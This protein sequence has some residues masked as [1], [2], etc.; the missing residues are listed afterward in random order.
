LGEFAIGSADNPV[1]LLPGVEFSRTFT[2]FAP[3]S[4][5][6]YYLIA[7][8][9]SGEAVSEGSGSGETNNITV[10]P[11][12]VSPAYRASVYT[13]ASTTLPRASVLLRGQALSN[14]NSSPVPYEFVKIG[15]ENKGTVRELDAFTDANGFFTRQFT[16]LDGEGGL[17]NIKAY[18]PGYPQEDPAPEDSFTILGMRFEQGDQRLTQLNPRITEGTTFAGSV[19]LQNLSATALT[20]LT[21]QAVGEPSDW[22]VQLSFPK[23]TLVGDEE[24]QIN[25]SI[26]VPD[27]KWSY[28][29]FG[30]AVSSAE[31]VQASLPVRVDV[32]QL[33]PKLVANQ[34]ILQASMLRGGQTLVEFQVRNEGAI[35]TGP[36]ELRLPNAPFLRA[37]SPLSLPSLNVGETTKVSLLLQPGADQELTVYNGSIVVAGA[38]ATLTLPFNFRAVSEA[39]GNLSLSVEDELTYFAEGSPLLGNATITLLDPFSGAVIF[40]ESDAD[41]VLLKQ[42]LAEGYYKLRVTADNHDSYEHTFYLGAGETESIQAFLSRQTVKYIWTV[43]PTEIEDK[44]TISIESVFETDVP[45]PVVTIDP[46][47]IDLQD[48]QVVGQ[49]MQMNMTLTNH[50]LIAANDIKLDFTSHPFYKL[51]PLLN[52]VDSLAAKSSLTIPVRITRINDFA[53]P[54]PGGGG[55]V[56]GGGGGGGGGGVGGGGGEPGGGSDPGNGSNPSTGIGGGNIDRNSP[57]SCALSGIVQWSYPCGETDITK[58]TEIVFW[59]VEGNCAPG[60]GSIDRS[61]GGIPS[62]DFGGGGGGGGGVISYMPIIVNTSNCNPCINEVSDRAKNIWLNLVSCVPIIGCPVGTYSCYD[63]VSDKDITWKDG[64]GCFSAVLGCAGFSL[65][66][67]SISIFLSY[68]EFKEFFDSCHGNGSFPSP[69]IPS[70][71]ESLATGNAQIFAYANL[72][73]AFDQIDKYVNRAQA[74]INSFTVI[75]GDNIWLKDQETN[76]ELKIWMEAFIAKTQGFTTTETT[77]STAERNELLGF[78]LPGKVSINDANQ[79]IDRWNRTVDYWSQGILNAIDVPSGQST[80]FISLDAVRKAFSQAKKAVIQNQAEGFDNASDGVIYAVDQLNRALE[81][82]SSG[83][84][85]SVTIKIDQEAVITRAAFLGNLEIENGNSTSLT[86]LAATLQIKDQKGNVV[87]DKFGITVPILDN[88]TA[89]DGTGIL[90]GDDPATPQKEGSGSAQWTFVPT[91]LAAPEIPTTYSIG[92]TLSYLEDG[93]TVTVPLVSTPITVFPQAELYLDYF[94]QRDVFADDPFT[95]D[96]IEPSVPYSLA[97]LIRNEGKGDAKNLRITS[98]QPKII[99]NE[100]GLLIDFQ[101]IGSEVNGQGVSPSLTVNFGDI[102]AGK[103][104]VADW[105]LKSSLQGKF[106]DYK[107]TFEHVNSLGKPELS[108][109]KDVKIHELIH[110]VQVTHA[111]PDQLPDFLVNET[112][113]AQFTPDI[114]Y[115]SSGGT[116]PVNAVKNATVDSAPS[117]SDLDVVISAQAQAGWTYFRLPE[118]SNSKLELVRLE[119]ADGSLVSMENI[120]TTDR[121]FLATGRPTYENI[122]YFLDFTTAGTTT[123]RAFYQPGGPSISQILPV[124]PDPIGTLVNSVTLDFSKPIT[125]SSFDLQDLT[126]TRDGSANLLTSGVTIQ[127]LSPTRYQISGLA[128]FTQLDGA[129]A[130]SVNAAGILDASGKAGFGTAVEQWSKAPGGAVDATPPQTLDVVDLLSDPRNQPVSSL[131]V[132]FSEP[133]DLSCFTWQDI[134]QEMKT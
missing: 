111:N 117:L 24:V 66:S 38:E 6:D 74:I 106:I 104:A 32:N 19:A 76:Q 16:P 36:L 29:N 124:S 123:Y 90:S 127:S 101:I 121:T 10:L 60:L 68:T 39:V 110:T 86:N 67:C 59:N 102:K 43:T 113:D 114:L 11:I 84:C 96:L 22:T 26:T 64:L 44:Y 103:T 9:D 20:G 92:G 79:F 131:V 8:T 49:V 63:G 58:A 1:N 87:N 35:P 33:L 72:A 129:Y 75:L 30:L 42:H 116:A 41:G 125:T 53:D 15:V 73:P 21:A 2:Y 83:V 57:V 37:A 95:D 56:G 48:L 107:A 52:Q 78:P 55:G 132:R 126:L 100:K 62:G 12:T 28:Y 81:G 46:P 25:Y 45:I 70:E 85:A 118:P 94:H 3:A 51:E 93:K 98:G 77:I 4:P 54:N 120:W 112:F 47:L 23:T 122:L 7:Q 18:F 99:E 134:T 14:Q 130:L 109:I 5:G 97:V 61:G 13:D 105:L 133:L 115:F 65:L 89:V 80:D 31:G 82:D 119:R 27:D 108:L 34:S 88:I 128:P 71:V 50:G 17:Y 40:S 69:N 91:T